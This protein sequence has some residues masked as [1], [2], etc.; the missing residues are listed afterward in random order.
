MTKSC[1]MPHP[2]V[3]VMNSKHKT[4][5]SDLLN[6]NLV[7]MSLYLGPGRAVPVSKVH[8]H[9]W[10]SEQEHE[11]EAEVPKIQ[12]TEELNGELPTGPIG[13]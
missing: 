7:L 12:S 3:L 11:A 8:E 13:K 1:Q 10:K 2:I 9:A 4:K 5:L 6:H